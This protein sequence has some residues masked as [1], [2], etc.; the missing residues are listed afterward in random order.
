MTQL[1]TVD[2]QTH[3]RKS[4]SHSITSK[5]SNSPKPEHTLL[6][7]DMYELQ[8]YPTSNGTIEN[9]HSGPKTKGDY[10]QV[11]NTDDSPLLKD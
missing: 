10:V 3:L 2:E 9:N 1:T 8:D 7:G 5:Q 11:Q 4:P 6:T